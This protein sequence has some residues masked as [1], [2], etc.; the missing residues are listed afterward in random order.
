MRILA[1]RKARWRCVLADPDLGWRASQMLPAEWQ[2]MAQPGFGTPVQ[3]ARSS[4]VQRVPWG[5][6]IVYCKTYVYATARDRRRGWLRTTWLAR[7]RPRREADALRW[8]RWHG[9]DA[10][11][12]LA[13]AELRRFGILHA[14]LILTEAVA[15]VPLSVCLPNL[16]A[17]DRSSVLR[18]LRAH[19][20]ALH[21]AGFR[22]RNLDLRNILLCGDPTQ[23]RFVKI[24]SPR[25]RLRRPGRTSDGLA[26]GDWQRLTS[27]L[28][29]LDLTW[30][31][32]A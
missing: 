5:E 15:G 22:D 23:P 32:D 14:A 17:A 4:W 9:F 13:V 28:A 26:R 24:D 6:N 19:V 20:T 12:P 25:F 18:A 30:P 27:S 11:R 31:P 10:P 8:L 7:S 3:A 29:A 21:R 16:D 1:Q 2:A